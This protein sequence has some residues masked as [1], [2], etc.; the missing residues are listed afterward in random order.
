MSEQ[1][2]DDSLSRGNLDVYDTFLRREIVL[3][4]VDEVGTQALDLDSEGR[5][6]VACY[7]QNM[8]EQLRVMSDTDAAKMYAELNT[9]KVEVKKG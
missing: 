2:H 6:S 4:L 7:L 5:E 9:D 8:A 3:K 1:L